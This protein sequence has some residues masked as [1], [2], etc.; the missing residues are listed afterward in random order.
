MAESGSLV[1]LG[2][3]DER[4]NRYEKVRGVLPSSMKSATSS[5]SQLFLLP[6]A[7]SSCSCH[8]LV[9]MAKSKNKSQQPQFPTVSSILLCFKIPCTSEQFPLLSKFY[10]DASL[11]QFGIFNVFFVETILGI[12]RILSYAQKK[13]KSHNCI[14]IVRGV[15]LLH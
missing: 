6:H 8:K 9:I 13:K 11:K 5:L 4:A 2:S 12:F 7:C 14:V 10:C 15:P 1:T 3:W